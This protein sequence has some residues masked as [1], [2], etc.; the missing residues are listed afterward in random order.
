M[1]LNKKVNCFLEIL[2]LLKDQNTL[3]NIIYKL[4]YHVLLKQVTNNI[5]IVFVHPG[6]S[7]VNV[8]ATKFVCALDNLNYD[9]SQH[10]E[11]AYD[12]IE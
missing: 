5:K 8:V 3:S 12:F 11:E 7:K 2:S 10:F 6:D 9:I 4:Y 1:H